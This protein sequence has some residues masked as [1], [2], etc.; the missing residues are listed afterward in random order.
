MMRSS[1]HQVGTTK[2]SEDLCWRLVRLASESRA[3]SLRDWRILRDSIWALE[4]T[5][6]RSAVCRNKETREQQTGRKSSFTAYSQGVG[7]GTI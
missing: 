7:D 5:K 4:P 2:W 6:T 3:S 1:T